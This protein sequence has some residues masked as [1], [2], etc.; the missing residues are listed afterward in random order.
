M[1]DRGLNDIKNGV[2]LILHGLEELQNDILQLNT[3]VNYLED[4]NYQNEEF[5]NQLENLLQERR[6]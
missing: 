1:L 4:K 2:S 6:K 5:F 3:K